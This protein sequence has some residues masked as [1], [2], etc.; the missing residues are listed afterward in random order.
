MIWNKTRIGE[1]LFARE[2][3]YKPDSIAI[4]GLKRVEKIDFSGN[5][6][7]VQKPSQT[8]MILIKSG[9]QSDRQCQSSMIPL[10]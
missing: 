4:G 8:D 5:F 1:F 6:H 7:I 3:K 10:Q 2:G 9:T